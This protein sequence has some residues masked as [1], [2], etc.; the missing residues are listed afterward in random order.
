MTRGTQARRDN[1]INRTAAAA[2]WE[3][4][5]FLFF[6]RMKRV[7]EVAA[8]ILPVSTRICVMSECDREMKALLQ[9][10]RALNGSNQN[11]K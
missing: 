9:L 6:P 8:G 10:L 1:Q 2:R 7:S 4:P 11:P 3:L 5:F